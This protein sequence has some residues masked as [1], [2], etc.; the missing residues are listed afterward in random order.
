MS[1]YIITEDAEAALWRA[2]LA[3]Q[4]MSHAFSAADGAACEIPGDQLAALLEL[5]R[6]QVAEARACA[7]FDARAG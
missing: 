6:E 2:D 1:G 4:A 5:V 3:L 7:R